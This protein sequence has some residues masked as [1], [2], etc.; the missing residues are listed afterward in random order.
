MLEKCSK[1]EKKCF[2]VSKYFQKKEIDLQMHLT[3]KVLSNKTLIQE[4]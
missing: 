3:K 4:K 2:K 1:S